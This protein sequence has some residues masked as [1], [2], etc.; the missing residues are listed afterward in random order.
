MPL[1][2]VGR[3]ER[4]PEN[5]EEGE[6][7]APRLVSL[8][9]AW[10]TGRASPYY[11]VGNKVVLALTLCPVSHALFLYSV[12]FGHG[13]PFIS[14]WYAVV[15][16]LYSLRVWLCIRGADYAPYGYGL[17]FR[18][19]LTLRPAEPGDGVTSIKR[20]CRDLSSDDVRELTT[21]PIR[22][23][24]EFDESKDHCLTLKNTPYP[25]QRYAI[26]NTLVNEEEEATSFYLNTSYPSRK[27]RRICACTSQGTTKIKE[28]YTISRNLYTPYPRFIILEDSKRYQTWSLLQEIP[29][30]PYPTSPDTAYRPV[31]RLYR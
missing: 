21:A 15:S 3:P 7:R 2:V 16:G 18:E 29:N 11:P 27:I 10:V 19:R 30:T 12:W 17:V 22:R 24:Q 13:R 8:S 6:W 28:L 20:R 31:S 25:H 26:Y 23:I 9:G 1:A 14:E 4:I 5:R